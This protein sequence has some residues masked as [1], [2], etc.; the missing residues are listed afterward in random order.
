MK[1]IFNKTEY[2]TRR[3]TLRNNMTEPEKKLWQILRGK[4]MGVKFRRQHGIGH[5]IADFYCPELKI[6]IEVDGDSHKS[7]EAQTYDAIRTDFMASLGI[8]TLRFTN[9]EVIHNIEGVH[10]QLTQYLPPLAPP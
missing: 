9:D 8:T 3:Q 2:K 5:Y 4:Q 1:Q 7:A 10:Q 6:V